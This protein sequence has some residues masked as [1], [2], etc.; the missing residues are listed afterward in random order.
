MERKK[1]S[2]QASEKKLAGIQITHKYMKKRRICISSPRKKYTFTWEWRTSEKI[3]MLDETKKGGN[4][5]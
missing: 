4:D 1:E 5:E 3:L 2:R